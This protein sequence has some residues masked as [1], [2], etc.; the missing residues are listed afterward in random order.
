MDINDFGWM[1][2]M[3]Y[4]PVSSEVVKN[5]SQAQIIDG[6]WYAPR[7]G[8]DTLQ[9]V[10]DEIEDSSNHRHSPDGLQ[11]AVLE[12]VDYH[13]EYVDGETIKLTRRR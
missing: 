11:D 7:W 1:M 3:G 8:C 6:Q 12:G 4:Y 2:R 13:L 5:H 10:K 9:H